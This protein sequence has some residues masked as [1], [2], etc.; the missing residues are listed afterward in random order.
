MSG[1]PRGWKKGWVQAEK[2]IIL[3]LALP[4]G[5]VL[6]WVIGNAL[7]KRFHTSWIGIAG[8]VLGAAAGL[9]RFVQGALAISGEDA[10]QDKRSGQ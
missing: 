1:G 7:D 8:I 10:D 2:M 5:T 3:G 9:T 4:I 6:G